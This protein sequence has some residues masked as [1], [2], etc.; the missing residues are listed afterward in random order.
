MPNPLT[1]NYVPGVGQLV[2]YRSDFESHVTGTG[3]RHTAD[4]IDLTAPLIINGSSPTTVTTVEQALVTLNANF[5]PAPSPATFS[6]LGTITLA[7]D[8]NGVGST[9]LVPQVGG[10]QGIPVS[11]NVPTNNQYL[12]FLTSS[13][14]W[15]PSSL[16]FSGD[17]T[18]TPGATVISSISAS[19]PAV[20]I[21]TN[22]N[23][24]SSN[25]ITLLS[26][27]TLTA[28]SGSTVNLNS[29]NTNFNS[30]SINF[31]ATSALN[32]T[33][34]S[35]FNGTRKRRQCRPRGCIR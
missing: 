25:I 2:T 17:V 24:T 12:Q 6:T 3:F 7:G 4:Q 31:S 20:P 21:G 15:T 14:K 10:L 30:A 13:G 22:M 33:T 34:G 1:P 19:G 11:N 35:T 26:G 27:S 29:T 23:L 18:G 8:L 9:A 28:N 16:T 32:F 5:L